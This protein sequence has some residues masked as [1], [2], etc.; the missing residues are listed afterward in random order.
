MADLGRIDRTI[1]HVKEQLVNCFTIFLPNLKSFSLTYYVHYSKE[2][3]HV[4]NVSRNSFLNGC[5]EN[6]NNIV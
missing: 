5:N 2:S 1:C 4:V 6:E 3:G